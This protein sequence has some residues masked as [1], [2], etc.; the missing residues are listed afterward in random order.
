M[1]CILPKAQEHGIWNQTAT[2]DG[3]LALAPTI[4]LCISFLNVKWG[5]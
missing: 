3:F 4:V 1:A 5:K 2:C